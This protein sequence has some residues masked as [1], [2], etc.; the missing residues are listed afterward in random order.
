LHPDKPACNTG[1][2]HS[3]FLVDA[4]DAARDAGVA[5]GGYDAGEIV[6]PEIPGSEKIRFAYVGDPE[7]NII[8]LQ[9]WWKDP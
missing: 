7:W 9:R 5:A 2:G 3:T 6:S 1:F 8:E 4:V